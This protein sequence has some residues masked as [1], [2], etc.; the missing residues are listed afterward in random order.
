M[1]ATQKQR[2]EFIRK[3]AEHI[4]N[5]ESLNFF[6]DITPL[7]EKLMRY[8]ATYC[9]I[10]E[11]YCND[12]MSDEQ[13]ARM[14]RKEQSLEKLISDVCQTLGAKAVFQGDPRGAT[15]KISVPDGFTDDWGRTGICVPTA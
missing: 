6:D 12:P 14:E 2:Q 13:Q 8:G 11:A 1:R 4:G 15:V 9:R 7:A 5:R 3:L 10:Q